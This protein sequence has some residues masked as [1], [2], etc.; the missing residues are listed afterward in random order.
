MSCLEH[1]ERELQRSADGGLDARERCLQ[2]FRERRPWVRRAAA[3]DRRDAVAD[4]DRAPAHDDGRLRI[5]ATRERFGP[6][7]V[8]KPQDV[9]KGRE[10]SLTSGR[11]LRDRELS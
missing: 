11:R 1:A 6:R 3:A 9:R 4:T 7:L 2:L 8:G 10:N 5:D